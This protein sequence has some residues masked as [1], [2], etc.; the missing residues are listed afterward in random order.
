[1]LWGQKGGLKRRELEQIRKFNIRD[2]NR[3]GWTLIAGGGW[4]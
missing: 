2:G 4:E 3:R 1:M